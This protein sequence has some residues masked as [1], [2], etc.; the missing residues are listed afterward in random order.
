MVR[1]RESECVDVE[2]VR[3]HLEAPLCIYHNQRRWCGTTLTDQCAHCYSC[4]SESRWQVGAGGGEL[5]PPAARACGAPC[6]VHVY[7]L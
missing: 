5:Q 7:N 4:L 2:S 3:Q 6:T 1:I